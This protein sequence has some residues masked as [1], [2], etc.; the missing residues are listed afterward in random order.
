MIHSQ[1]T[2]IARL[3]GRLVKNGLVER[4]PDEEDRRAVKLY[5]TQE[6]HALYQRLLPVCNGFYQ[7][8]IRDIPQDELDVFRSVLDRL[9]DNSQKD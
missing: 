7:K 3:G 8:I 1:E 6:G 2:T 4:R 9:V 5:C